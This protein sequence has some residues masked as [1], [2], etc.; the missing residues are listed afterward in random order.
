MKSAKKLITPKR[1][2]KR[3]KTVETKRPAKRISNFE[4]RLED[5]RNVAGRLRSALESNPKMSVL[6]F[7][8]KSKFKSISNKQIVDL[9]RKHFGDLRINELKTDHLNY[10]FGMYTKDP[11]VRE[12]IIKRINT[13][14]SR[15]EYRIVRQRIDFANKYKENKNFKKKITSAIKILERTNTANKFGNFKFRQ[16]SQNEPAFKFLQKECPDLTFNEIKEI[17]SDYL[18]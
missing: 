11:K 9:I 2:A 17:I 14:P 1:P 18:K 13:D 3:N 8:Q 16:L 5:Q 4:I 6:E 10:L 15:T 12:E 7:L